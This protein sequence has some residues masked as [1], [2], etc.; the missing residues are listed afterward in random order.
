ML[1]QE[2]TVQ[3]GMIVRSLYVFR[4]LLTSEI[5][6]R[7]FR[8]HTRAGRILLLPILRRRV[9]VVERDTKMSGTMGIDSLTASEISYLRHNQFLDHHTPEYIIEYDISTVSVTQRPKQ[10]MKQGYPSLKSCQGRMTV[11]KLS[12]ISQTS[13]SE[14]LYFIRLFP[15]WRQPETL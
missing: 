3:Y 10:G 6:P 12:A 13:I 5:V 8:N 11:P 7:A 1:R 4:L 14:I 2:V 9:M 15:S